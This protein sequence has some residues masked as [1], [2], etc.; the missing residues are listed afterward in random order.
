MLGTSHFPRGHRLLLRLMLRDSR[1][2]MR[3][4]WEISS[5]LVFFSE[6]TPRPSDIDHYEQEVRAVIARL[7]LL[8][9]NFE[10]LKRVSLSG[11]CVF[12][13]FASISKLCARSL[14]QLS[15]KDYCYEGDV[16]PTAFEG[17]IGKL[18]K[19]TL[20][21]IGAARCFASM[22][23]SCAGSLLELDLVEYIKGAYH[24][25]SLVIDDQR[26]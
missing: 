24:D 11:W 23:A 9:M 3:E 6:R 8:G 7:Q 1:S 12:E 16:M 25:T 22:S 5:S 10:K 2:A 17:E 21:G 26:R 18:K 15:C 13:G 4:L 14:V 19:L 20:A